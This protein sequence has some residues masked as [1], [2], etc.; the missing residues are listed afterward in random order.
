M[1]HFGV[2]HT[3]QNSLVTWYLEK[4]KARGPI[5]TVLAIFLL[6]YELGLSDDIGRLD[7]ASCNIATM[8]MTMT[9]EKG[10]QSLHFNLSLLPSFHNDV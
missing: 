2:A 7:L 5:L 1:R 4:R 10:K 9:V 6:Y 3:I 8:N